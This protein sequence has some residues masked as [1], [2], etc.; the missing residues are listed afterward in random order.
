ML[1]DRRLLTLTGIGGVGKTRL[2]LRIASSLQR[3]FQEG[4]VW[5]VQLGSLREPALVARAVADVL[6]VPDLG[7]MSL[8][9]R[10]GDWLGNARTLLLIDNC[11]H[12]LDAAA[13]LAE[14]LL[15][16]C[17]RLHVLTTSRQALGVS[18]EA[19]LVVQPLALDDARQ[20]FLERAATRRQ[21]PTRRRSTGSATVWTGSRWPWSWRRGG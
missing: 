16:A 7:R 18:G 9:D 2:A 4:G 12:L 5:L 20:L 21:P 15:G 6:R 3:R 10:M 13:D 17:P 1:A 11:E 8:V 14:R 19:V